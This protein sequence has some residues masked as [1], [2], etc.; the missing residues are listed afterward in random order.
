MPQAAPAAS[1]AAAP[2]NPPQPAGNPK[3][4][5]WDDDHGKP[6]VHSLKCELRNMGVV[7]NICDSCGQSSSVEYPIPL[8]GEDEPFTCEMNT[9]NPNMAFCWPEAAWNECYADF[10]QRHGVKEFRAPIINGQPVNLWYLYNFITQM[11]GW[12]T[13]KQNGWLPIIYEEM[14]WTSTSIATRLKQIYETYLLDFE[15]AHF[16]G[17]RYR[18][19]E[20]RTKLFRPRDDKPMPELAPREDRSSSAPPAANDDRVK[21]RRKRTAE[22]ILEAEPNTKAHVLTGERVWVKVHNQATSPPS[23]ARCSFPHQVDL[24]HQPRGVG[25]MVVGWEAKHRTPSFQ[26]ASEARRRAKKA[27]QN[28]QNHIL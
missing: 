26:S 1:P 2:S 27:G 18:S 3:K 4:I 8:A 19:L 10:I 17:K 13:V 9:W 14:N 25:R 15:N 24:L 7:W 23:Q 11:G 12:E 6:D 16:F 22:E 21:K 5:M 20:E 28:I